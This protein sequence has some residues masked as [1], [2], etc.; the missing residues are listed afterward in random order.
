MVG[1][2]SIHSRHASLDSKTNTGAAGVAKKA[3]PITRF[4][5]N[6]GS[7]MSNKKANYKAHKGKYSQTT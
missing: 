1:L 2:H 7:R 4:L 3:S 6:I 5:R